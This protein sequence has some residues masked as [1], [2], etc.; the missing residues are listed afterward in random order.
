VR[1]VVIISGMCTKGHPIRG[2][3]IL[4]VQEGKTPHIHSGQTHLLYGWNRITEQETRR[5][6]RAWQPPEE[7][8]REYRPLKAETDSKPDKQQEMFSKK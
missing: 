8:P 2:E 5:R 7:V 4:G 3:E 6:V 1:D